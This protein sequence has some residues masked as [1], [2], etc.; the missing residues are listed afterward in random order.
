MTHTFSIDGSSEKGRALIE[1]LR[2]LDF[3]KE[4]QSSVLTDEH[5]KELNKR[6]AQFINNGKKGMSIDEVEAFARNHRK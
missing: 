6:R 4:E 5:L 1:Y 2:T 3:V